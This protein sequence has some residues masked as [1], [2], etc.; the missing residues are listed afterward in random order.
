ML[1]PGLAYYVNRPAE[2]NDLPPELV[3]HTADHA[4]FDSFA[5][6]RVVVI[7]GGQSALESAALLHE[8]GA[9]VQLVSRSPLRCARGRYKENRSFFARVK[10]PKAGIAPGWFNLGLE[11]F[12][13]AFQH[14]PR[15]VKDR[16]LRG[17]ARFGTCRGLLAARPIEGK[18]MLHELRR[19]QE[20][21]V[22]DHCVMLRLSDNTSLKADHIFLRPATMSISVDYPCCLPRC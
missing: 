2:Y 9:G 5:G 20:L 6:K 11:R 14:F 12:P 17:R 3:S 16:L 19:V 8:A 7:G 18:V 4:Q 10:L 22:E 21:K 13:Y 1:A 15:N